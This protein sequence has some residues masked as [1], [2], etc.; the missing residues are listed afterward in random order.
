[1]KRTLYLLAILP[2]LAGATCQRRGEAPVADAAPE[3]YQQHVVSVD[4]L[5]TGVTWSCNAEDPLCW[6]ELQPQVI[7][8]LTEKL[9]GAVRSQQACIR[10]IESLDKQ[11]VIRR[12]P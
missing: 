9:G 6:D 7:K 1:M 5:N 10:F 8:P 11:G 4:P 3:C 2:M 12:K